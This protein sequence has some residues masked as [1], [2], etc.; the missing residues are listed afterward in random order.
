[1]QNEINVFLFISQNHFLEKKCKAC[2][3]K[4][5]NVFF[6]SQNRFLLERKTCNAGK[7]NEIS[8]FYFFIFFE[9]HFCFFSFF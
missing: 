1:M 9:I 7:K 8:V 6:I 3:I 2:G 5:F 4:I